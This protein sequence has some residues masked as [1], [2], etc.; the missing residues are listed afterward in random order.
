MNHQSSPWAPCMIYQTIA[1][2]NASWPWSSWDN[3]QQYLQ[4][5][6]LSLHIQRL[7]LPVRRFLGKIAA[8]PVLL[9]AVL[10]TRTKRSE[11]DA[12]LESAPW[13]WSSTTTEVPR[14]KRKH[15]RSP[16]ET[17]DQFPYHDASSRQL[18]R[19][20]QIR[21]LHHHRRL[22]H[23]PVAYRRRHCHL[24]HYRCRHPW[25]FPSFVQSAHWQ[26]PAYHAIHHIQPKHGHVPPGPYQKDQN[27]IPRQERMTACHRG[28]A[29]VR[30]PVL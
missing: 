24:R 1:R 21:V 27:R 16:A 17:V 3:P 8:Q 13:R 5:S 28:G 19:Q 4:Q 20:Q 23:P 12:S 7:R 9:F 2:D 18:T 14:W 10:G 15:Q 22:C 6:P 26:L 11:L 25:P 29:R 30:L